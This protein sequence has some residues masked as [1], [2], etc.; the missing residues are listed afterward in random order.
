MRT[1]REGQKQVKKK[2][3]EGEDEERQRAEMN[4][5]RK[6]GNTEG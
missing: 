6:N 2:K 1:Q 4:D 3:K 5:S